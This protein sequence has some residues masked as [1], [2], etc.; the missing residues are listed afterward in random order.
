MWL[1][2]RKPK[3]L[4]GEK[5]TIKNT[6]KRL[7]SYVQYIYSK[8]LELNDYDDVI[9]SSNVV[10]KGKSGA[11]NEFDV[12]YQ[13][14]HLNIECKVAIE[15]KDWKEPVPVKEVRD[16]V[17]KIEDVGMGQMIGVMVSKNGYQDGA[18]KF[19]E[20][21][22]IKLLKENDLP[23]IPQLLAGIIQKGFLPTDKCMGEPFW[24]IM[25]YIDGSVTGSYMSVNEDEDGL[26]I[27]PLF[28]SKKIAERF[29]SKK[30]DADKFCVRGITQYHLRSL[31]ALEA[32]GHPQFAV[33][34]LPV[35]PEDE[36]L[37]A[38]IFEANQIAELYLRK[39]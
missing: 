38:I 14:S 15:C 5:D 8:L 3:R 20:A 37:P 11:T 30:P 16:F 12:F 27:I 2:D 32:L 4:N 21:N 22:G 31:L 33:F 39:S 13:F 35:I 29:L 9:I 34:F 19:A 24:T 36:Q 28:Y 1:I 7:E 25:E 10:I 18:Q 17:A 23:S 26:P 6:G